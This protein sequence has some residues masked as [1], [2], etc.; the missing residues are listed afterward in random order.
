MTEAKKKKIEIEGIREATRKELEEI[1][2][3]KEI[4]KTRKNSKKN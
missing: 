3:I 2:R 1:E 4:K